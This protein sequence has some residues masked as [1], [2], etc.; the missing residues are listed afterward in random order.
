[1]EFPAFP[2]K[3]I[4]LVDECLKSDME[5]EFNV[6]QHAGEEF[7]DEPVEPVRAAPE[8]DVSS[9]YCRLD[10]TSGVMQLVEAN[11]FKQVVHISLQMRQG[12]DAAIKA[13]LASRLKLA[14]SQCSTLGNDLTST[15]KA[16]KEELTHKEEVE[17]ELNKF[18]THADVTTES[19]RAAHTEEIS[20]LQMQLMDSMDQQRERYET[21]LQSARGTIDSLHVEV[22]AKAVE[23]EDSTIELKREKQHLEFRERELARLL[24]TAE[25]DRDRVFDECRKINEQKRDVDDVRAGLERDLARSEARCE[26]LKAQVEDR[27]SMV[28]KSVELQKASDEA[29]KMVEDK[30]DIYIADNENLHEKIKLGSTEIT[31]GNAVIQR[32]QA[33]KKTLT[34]KLK[35]K[36]DVIRKQEDVVE[37]LKTRLNEADRIIFTERETT[38]TMESKYKT[39]AEQLTESLARL[40]ESAKLISSNQEV[41]SYLNEE[42]NK[43]QLG[44]RSGTEAE[45]LIATAHGS[46]GSGIGVSES[47]KP[48]KWKDFDQN[49][50][51][52]SAAMFSPD[53]TKDNSYGGYL[54]SKEDVI[55]RG[56]QNLGLGGSFVSQSDV[57]GYGLGESDVPLEQMAYYADA[58]AKSDAKSAGPGVKPYAWQAEDFGLQ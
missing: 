44:L 7:K 40:E 17:E 49:T 15:T 42:I 55:S 32:L 6:A 56:L 31:K 51:S 37:E 48:S 12:N 52:N 16:L 9:F 1:M 22:K 46:G 23:L 14:L 30:L 3:L 38:K 28:K 29:R 34:E 25:A 19:L 36:S 21:Q 26:A 35:T 4:E 57:H 20:K 45:A 27:D 53:T 11:K 2:A 13:Y 33:D 47:V 8:S 10:T 50:S 41:I 24:E 18:K 39:A 5:A 43:W 58:E 54:D